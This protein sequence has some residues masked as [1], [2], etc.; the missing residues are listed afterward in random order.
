MDKE[1]AKCLGDQRALARAF[2]DA[3]QGFKDLLDAAM[4]R[5]DG[6]EQSN[7]LLTATSAAAGPTCLH[8]TRLCARTTCQLAG[9]SAAP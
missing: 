7:W 4:M 3:R 9:A 5:L 6:H 1:L 8:P 2:E